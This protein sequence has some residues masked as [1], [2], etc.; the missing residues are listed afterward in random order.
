MICGCTHNKKFDMF[1]IP[2]IPFIFGLF[3][4]L[5][6]LWDKLPTEIKLEIIEAIIS[7]FV[8]LFKKFY[9]NQKVN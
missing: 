1:L 5:F 4:F 2:A 9:R 6:D 3:K 8:E 7:T